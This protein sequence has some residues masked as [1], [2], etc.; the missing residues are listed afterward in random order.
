MDNRWWY[1]NNLQ[2]DG[3]IKVSFVKS[4]DNVSNLGTKNVTTEVYENLEGRFLADR[5]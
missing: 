1:V 5:S 2:T 4:A 3:L